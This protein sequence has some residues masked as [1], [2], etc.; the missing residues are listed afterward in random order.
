MQR[1]DD[2]HTKEADLI[3]KPDLTGFNK[4]DTSQVDALITKG[5]EASRDVLKQHEML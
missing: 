1:A 2:F 4:A 5:Y 3:I